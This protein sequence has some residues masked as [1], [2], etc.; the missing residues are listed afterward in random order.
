MRHRDQFVG[1]DGSH[2]TIR[3]AAGITVISA[4]GDWDFVLPV[5]GGLAGIDARVQAL[6][7]DLADHYIASNKWLVRF[8]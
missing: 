6:S 4:A 7:L 3:A 1:C 2:S 8:R 5:P